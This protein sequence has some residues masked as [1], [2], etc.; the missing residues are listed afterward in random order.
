MA[1]QI[2]RAR[3]DEAA[4]LSALAFRSKAAWGYDAAFMA[5]CRDELSVTPEQVAGNPTFVYEAG[6]VTA[7]FYMLDFSAG[8]ADVALFFVA[9]EAMRRG[10]GGALWR[11]MC[12]EANRHGAAAMTIDSDPHAVGFYRRMG[13]RAAGHA[14]AGGQHRT[15]AAA[16]GVRAGA[17][18]PGG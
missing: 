9:P 12:D 8:V 11:H 10:V 5:A 18:A 13:A 3:A 1:A 17:P 16:S 4:A 6:D 15:Q 7:G 14:Q 2:R